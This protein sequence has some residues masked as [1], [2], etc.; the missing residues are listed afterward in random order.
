MEKGVHPERSH[1]RKLELAHEAEEKEK[2][3]KNMM[4]PVIH[5]YTGARMFLNQEQKNQFF[6]D[7][8]SMGP[9]QF[10]Q[11]GT[12][13]AGT[14]TGSEPSPGGKSGYVV[15]GQGFPPPPGFPLPAGSGPGSAGYAP[16]DIPPPTAH[17]PATGK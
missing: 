1:K 7:L 9:E 5:P 10:G 4:F 16:L 6:I 15:P 3:E 11:G 17:G 8:Q 2:R 14:A 12:T 13:G